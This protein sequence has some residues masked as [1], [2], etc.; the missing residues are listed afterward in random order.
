MR[1]ALVLSL[2]LPLALTLSAQST[3]KP[4]T[5]P[6]PKVTAP[7]KES[8]EA[9]A[10]RQTLQI[11][12]NSINDNWF[13]KAYQ[14]INAVDI[15]GSL[16]IQVSAAALNAKVDQLSQGA[17]KGGIAQNGKA[18]LQVKS[19]YFA[20]A[21]FKTEMTGS[22]G[23]L[24][25]TRVG[26]RGFLYSQTQNAYTT[27]VE[28]GPSDAPLSYLGWFRSMLNDIKAVYVDGP[29][30]K[31]SFGKEESVGGKSLQTLVF[32]APTSVYDPKK[33]EQ[34]LADSM[35]FWKRGRLAVQVDK[36]TRLPQR[37][38][39]TNDGQGIRTQMDFTYDDKGHPLSINISNQ[40]RG[41]EGPGFLK[42]GYGAN[43]LMSSVSGELNGQDKKVGFDLNLAWAKGKKTSS[44]QSVPPPTASKR[45]SE[46]LEIALLTGLAQN[47]LELQRV[48]LNLRSV[49]LAAK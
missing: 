44:I 35:G 23:N 28:P 45:S 27:R 32:S 26:N 3:P 21:D 22:F 30:F 11:V 39:F 2:P 7:A 47:I 10:A 18:T 33:R 6:Q 25:Y 40:S 16:S 38:N 36:T 24:L 5:T 20:N 42:V 4:Q 13:G 1:L 31:A 34:S 14:D 17:L 8:P 37:M 41:M 12:L 15:Q 48:G 9:Q 49:S 29:V 46:D 19:T 43:G